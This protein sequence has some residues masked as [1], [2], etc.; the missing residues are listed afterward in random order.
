MVLIVVTVM[1]VSGL[2][3][4]QV[5]H[6]CSHLKSYSLGSPTFQGSIGSPQ[7]GKVIPPV[8]KINLFFRETNEYKLILPCSKNDSEHSF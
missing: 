2:W 6:V 3:R 8:Q 1:I 7:M 4:M 5:D